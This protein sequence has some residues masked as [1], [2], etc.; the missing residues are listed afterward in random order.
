MGNGKSIVSFAAAAEK[1]TNRSIFII[2]LKRNN[3]N[4]HDTAQHDVRFVF[5]AGLRC[6]AICFCSIFTHRRIC[7]LLLGWVYA[8][9]R[10]SLLHCTY[11]QLVYT[12]LP[13][14]IR[15]AYANIR[16]SSRSNAD[17]PYKR[18]QAPATTVTHM[19]KTRSEKSQM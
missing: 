10:T 11:I 17:R 5:V 3:S 2:Y 14:T 19:S 12:L 6:V 15:R 4:E 1:R 9:K 8:C 18:T 7:L 13:Y 16:S